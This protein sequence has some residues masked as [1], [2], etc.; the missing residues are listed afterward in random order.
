MN[1]T[2]CLA[3]I[4]SGSIK[5]CFIREKPC[6]SKR[7]FDSLSDPKGSNSRFPLNET[8]FIVLC[9]VI[10]GAEDCSDIALLARSKTDF[11]GRFF[12]LPHG[13]PSYDTFSRVFRHL[14]P[15]VFHKRFL[16]FMSD[17]AANIKGVGP[18]M[19]N[20]LGALM[21]MS[22]NNH[23]YTL[24]MTGR[25]SNVWY[26]DSLR[27]IKSQT[28]SQLF[29]IYLSGCRYRSDENRLGIVG[30][31]LGQGGQQVRLTML[32]AIFMMHLLEEMLGVNQGS[33]EVNRV[34]KN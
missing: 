23:H 25:W 3:S 12:S 14:D 26:C 28:K 31:Y 33:D 2:Y 18:R 13:T 17:V 27:S 30:Q 16:T 19:V 22:M 15:Q 32:A 4:H 7:R 10:S 6:S 9:V 29:P 8:L 1:W 34:C 21:T 11:L 20:I 24:S 5:A